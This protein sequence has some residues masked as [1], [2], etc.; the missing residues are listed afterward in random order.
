MRY[1]ARG[2]QGSLKSNR[3]L[4]PG[5]ESIQQLPF[6]PGGLGEH[7]WAHRTGITIRK[8]KTVWSMVRSPPPGQRLNRLDSASQGVQGR[9]KNASRPS[10]P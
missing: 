4:K 2:T 8:V 6:L 1:L 3:V 10:I 5:R 7:W 9:T